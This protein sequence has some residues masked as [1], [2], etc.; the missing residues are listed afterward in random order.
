M[1]YIIVR[2]IKDKQVWANSWIDENTLGAITTTK[3]LAKI[4]ELEKGSENTIAVYRCE[5]SGSP[6]IICGEAE[7]DKVD[8]TINYVSFKNYNIRNYS[9]PLTA[10][11]GQTHYFY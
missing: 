9:P 7:I 5:Y 2:H 8:T 4:C 3:E 1:L 10:Q 11:Q 6:A